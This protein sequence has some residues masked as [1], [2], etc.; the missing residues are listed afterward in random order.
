MK[1]L[2]ILI[3]LMIACI[4][5]AEPLESNQPTAFMVSYTD[6]NDTA[7]DVNTLSWAVCK[8]WKDISLKANGMKVMF[9]CQYTPLDVNDANDPND[10]TFDYT[11][12]VSD[13]GGAAQKVASGSATCGALQLSHNPI[14]IETELNSGDPSS[15]WCWVDTL[16]TLT[17]E[18]KVAPTLQ[19]E[20]GNNDAASFIFD[21]Q[22]AKKAKC[23]FTGID[24]QITVHCVSY[25]Y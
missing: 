15:N 7:F 24:A 19:N 18:W 14:S 21:R 1:K 17:S 3:A 13:Y 8:D 20:G 5:V 6:T 22:T 11:F 4:A 12:Y 9:Y 10:T 23:V 16:G 25:D 2:V